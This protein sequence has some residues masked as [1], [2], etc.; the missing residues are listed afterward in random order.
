MP[1][2]QQTSNGPSV[3]TRHALQALPP[4]DQSAT[5]GL[6]VELGPIVQ[7]VSRE[8]AGQVPF[9]RIEELLRE[10]LEREFSE[11]RVTTFLPVFLR[12]YACETLRADA[13]EARQRS[14]S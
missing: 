14:P 6:T 2:M 10:M 8:L 3:D 9:E 1:P 13:A 12:R 11:A 5:V 4:G 7:A